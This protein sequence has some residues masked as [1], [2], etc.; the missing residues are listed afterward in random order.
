MTHYRVKF[1]CYNGNI[2][3]ECLWTTQ[4]V[5]II[6][7]ALWLLTNMRMLQLLGELLLDRHNYLTMDRYIGSADNLKL[8][9][10][11]LADGS[12]SIAYEAFHV[13]KVR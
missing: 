4:R 10:T 11:M 7:T 6:Y 12:R 9:M 1:P 8:M 3:K 5:F 13:F 2:S